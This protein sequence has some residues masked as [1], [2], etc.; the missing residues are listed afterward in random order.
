MAFNVLDQVTYDLPPS[1]EGTI[2]EYSIYYR[3][4]EA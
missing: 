4:G 1:D 3:A 2:T